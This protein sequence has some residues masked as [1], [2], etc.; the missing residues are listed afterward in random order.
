[1]VYRCL[2]CRS[3]HDSINDAQLHYLSS[4]AGADVS[5]S[6]ADSPLNG[7]MP[8][9]LNTP[10]PVGGMNLLSQLLRGDSK[11]IEKWQKM[12]SVQ[13]KLDF[14]VLQQQQM[15][16]KLRQQAKLAKSKLAQEQRIQ[17]IQ[18]RIQQQQQQ[19]LQLQQQQRW[20]EIEQQQQHLQQQIKLQQLQQLKKQQKQQQQDAKHTNGTNS[21]AGPDSMDAFKEQIRMHL[22]DQLMQSPLAEMLQRGDFSFNNNVDLGMKLAALQQTQSKPQFGESLDNSPQ[23]PDDF[24]D[25]EDQMHNFSPQSDLLE[26]KS[27]DS[28]LEQQN[29]FNAIPE[30][31]TLLTSPPKPGTVAKSMF[32][33]SFSD[34]FPLN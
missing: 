5:S 9:L 33:I 25:D 18:Q 22:R 6:S 8:N 29:Q 19:R 10:K 20:K 7:Q 32:A 28:S 34:F 26:H 11:R 1:M 3:V 24:N 31:N 30:L 21:E 12:K 17:H 15:R 14:S 13:Q 2:V 27:D 16:Q 4:H 23:S